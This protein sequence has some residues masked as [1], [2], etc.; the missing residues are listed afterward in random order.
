[1]KNIIKTQLTKTER[2]TIK[3]LVSQ[4]ETAV[5]SKLSALTEEERSRY[6]SVNEQN[7]LLVNKTRDFRQN[8]PAMSSP[9]VDWNEF[10]SDYESRVFLESVANRLS[11]IAYQM[12]STKI[13]HDYDNYQDA[14]N[15]YAHAQ[16][17]KGVGEAGYTEK[18]AE[19]KQFFARTGKNKPSDEENAEN[20]G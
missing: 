15:D 4:L 19:L 18:V 14:L 12:Q 20:K 7:K 5:A 1:M 11:N 8:Q 16:Y 2:E 9:D 17:K 3:D 13:L 10:E 6:G